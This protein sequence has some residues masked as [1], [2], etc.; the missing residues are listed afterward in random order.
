MPHRSWTGT[1]SGLSEF[2]DKFLQEERSRGDLA[3]EGSFRIDLREA[4]RKMALFGQVEQGAW[5]L[6]L[7]QAFCRLGCRELEITRTSDRWQF[8]GTGPERSLDRVELRR[9]L[10]KLGLGGG[11]EA[12]DFLAVGLSALAVPTPEGK[13][14]EAACW[15]EGFE[16]EPLFGEWEDDEPSL[17][18]PSLILRFSRDSSPPLPRFLWEDSFSYSTMPVFYKMG[19]ESRILLNNTF[20]TQFMARG[21]KGRFWLEL[22]LKGRE[23]RD[24]ALVPTGR[25]LAEL[26]EKILDH[27]HLQLTSEARWLGVARERDH[28]IVI[29]ARKDLAGPTEIYPVVA[30]CLLQPVTRHNLGDGFKIVVTAEHCP[31]DLGHSQLRDSP[32]L[33]QLIES[34]K[35]PLQQALELIEIGKHKLVQKPKTPFVADVIPGCMGC[36]WLWTLPALFVEPLTGIVVGLI[37]G[38]T[39]GFYFWYT[40]K[41]CREKFEER[42]TGLDRLLEERGEQV[43]PGEQKTPSEPDH[44]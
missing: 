30:G 23:I 18:G 3:D 10:A 44:S 19:R 42:K 14:L 37:F 35:S 22:L 7:G 32:E 25:T 2:I 41:R 28:S 39:P 11:Q 29:L 4:A 33:E 20:S 43:E 27:S 40:R 13:M 36:I 16:S 12:E 5:T 38:G 1:V 21:E 6:K 31:C 17:Q 34:C 9:C 8:D 15:V 24:L 26:G